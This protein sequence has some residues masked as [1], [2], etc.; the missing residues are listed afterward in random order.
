MMTVERAGAGDDG[1]LS[2]SRRLFDAW[3]VFAS[4]RAAIAFMFCWAFAEAIVWPII[5]DFLLV[6]LAIGNRRRFYVPLAA[7]IAGSATGGAALYLFAYW[8]PD[9]AANFLSALPLVSDGQ[10]AEASRKLANE[11]VSAFWRQPWS[12][13][14][15]KVWGLIAG[16]EGLPPS[17]AIPVFMIA[18][19]VRMALFAALAAIVVRVLR[20]FVRDLT[21]FVLGT[22]LV[23]FFYGWWRTQLAS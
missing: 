1:L 6:L 19:A 2:A 22:Y 3:E 4:S 23:L 14:P 5:P 17:Q 21:L 10:V 13:V 9:L 12:G 20:P 18:R 15:F 7:A 11:G 8:S 16:A